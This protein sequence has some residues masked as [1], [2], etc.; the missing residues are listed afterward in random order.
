AMRTGAPIYT[1]PELHHECGFVMQEEPAPADAPAPEAPAE[2]TLEELE[3]LRDEAV[4]N[5]NYEE[6]S[7][8]TELI[9][10]KKHND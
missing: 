2:P 8:L 9:N 10:Q 5:E 4:A 6:A 7:R 3:R 1:T